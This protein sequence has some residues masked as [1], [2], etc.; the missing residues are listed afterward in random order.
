MTIRRYLKGD[1]LTLTS[2]KKRYSVCFL[3]LSCG[4]K[5]DLLE[6]EFGEAEALE[7]E[8]ANG[9][10]DGGEL[11]AELEIQE[12]VFMSSYIPRSLHEVMRRY[13]TARRVN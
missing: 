8:H 12:A 3:T 5:Q 11:A 7:E 10:G 6:K 4:A 1:A 9:T 13:D 2:L